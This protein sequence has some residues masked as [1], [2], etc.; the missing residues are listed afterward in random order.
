VLLVNFPN[1]ETVNVLRGK[2]GVKG[3]SGGKIVLGDALVVSVSP[4]WH[5]SDDQ[6]RHERQ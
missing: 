6:H 3:A 5:E 2:S 4:K 1:I